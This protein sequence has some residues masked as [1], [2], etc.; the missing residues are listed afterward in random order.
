MKTV[1]GDVNLDNVLA[2]D[3]EALTT[4]GDVSIHFPGLQED[5][6]FDIQTVSGD[7]QNQNNSMAKGRR[8]YKVNTVS[9]DVQIR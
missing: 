5:I 3:L 8:I 2:Q 4:S 1:S 6:K 9:G 7:V